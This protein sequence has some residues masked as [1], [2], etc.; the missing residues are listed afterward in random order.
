MLKLLKVCLALAI[1][2]SFVFFAFAEDEQQGQAV[3]L[4]TAIEV[5]GN[6]A[7]STNTIISKMK[8]GIGSPYQ[9]NIISDDLKRLY[10]LGF[11]SDIKIDTEPYKDGIKIIL[12]V[13]ERPLIEKITFEG[14]K[15]I[16]M[17]DEKLKE[18][19]KS[20]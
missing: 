5:K 8:S 6:K 2:F 14:I 3:K 17:R 11:F 12:T 7:I 18:S 4:I 15:R 20:K 1:F 16:T 10:L 13:A 19:L 9:E